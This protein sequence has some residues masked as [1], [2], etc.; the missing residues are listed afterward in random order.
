MA[1]LLTFT[2]EQLKA[3][4][5]YDPI[6]GWLFWEYNPDRPANWNSRFAG[7]AAG[8]NRHSYISVGISNTKYYAHR[9]IWKWLYG[10]DPIDIDHVNG[11]TLDNRPDNLREATFSQNLGNANFGEFRGVEKHGAKYR[12]RVWSQGLRRELGSYAT[13]EEAL[14]AYKAGADKIWAEYAFHN[15][16][17]A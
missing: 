2:Q 4:F 13:L 6:S 12:A 10:Y 7:K 17:A 3:L 15:R 9:L 8:S 11:D 16:E 14:V 1:K 5:D